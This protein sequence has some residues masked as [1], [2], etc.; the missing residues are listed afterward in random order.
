MKHIFSVIRNASKPPGHRL[1][2]NSKTRKKM[3]KTIRKLIFI[4]SLRIYLIMPLNSAKARPLEKSLV[5]A[6]LA[7]CST[8]DSETISKCDCNHFGYYTFNV[9][10]R[11]PVV[12]VILYQ[13]EQADLRSSCI[14]VANTR[15]RIAW[16]KYKLRHD[17]RKLTT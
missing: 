6:R 16:L 12:R 1:K 10:N 8:M 14:H 2:L 15:F 5:Q 9:A 13:N 11:N 4:V 17:M 3:P 7:T